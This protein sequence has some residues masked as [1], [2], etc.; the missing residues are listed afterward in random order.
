[1]VQAVPCHL[2]LSTGAD[3]PV[4]SIPPD[5][6]AARLPLCVQQ[7]ALFQALGQFSSA[8]TGSRIKKRLRASARVRMG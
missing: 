1:M 4:Y 5:S 3:L 8:T 6:L 2:L 7:R